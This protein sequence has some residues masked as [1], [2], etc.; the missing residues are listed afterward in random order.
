MY[1]IK[2]NIP[3][4]VQPDVEPGVRLSKRHLDELVWERNE[5]F[6]IKWNGKSPFGWPQKSAK[7]E[8]LPGGPP[9]WVVRSGS[10]KEEPG[11]TGYKYSIYDKDDTLIVDPTVFID[12]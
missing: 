10:A 5:D 1:S 9:L 7:D 3:P 11:P 2:I 8:T 12:P 6:K 4:R